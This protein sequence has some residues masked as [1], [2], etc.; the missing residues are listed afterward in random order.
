MVFILVLHPSR[1]AAPKFDTHPNHFF[2]SPGAAV[3]NTAAPERSQHK[4]CRARC[5][6]SHEDCQDSTIPT[7][8]AAVDAKGDKVKSST[9]LRVLAQSKKEPRLMNSKEGEKMARDRIELP[10]RGFSVP[11]WWRDYVAAIGCQ[12]N[13]SKGLEGDHLSLFT[14]ARLT[15][16][17]NAF[18]RYP[19]LFCYCSRKLY[20][21]DLGSIALAVPQRPLK[22]LL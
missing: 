3:P 16:G 7:N 8:L 17:P 10:T 21:P 14:L 12:L 2:R 22:K 15:L 5:H 9:A 11:R 18:K 1:L 4:G 13:G 6:L 19:S 20:I